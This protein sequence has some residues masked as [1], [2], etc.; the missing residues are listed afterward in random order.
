MLLR[1]VRPSFTMPQQFY[2]NMQHLRY[3]EV[4]GIALEAI[5]VWLHLDIQLASN[6]IIIDVIECRKRQEWATPPYLGVIF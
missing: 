1:V 6:V 2:Y 5:N 3:F 4:F